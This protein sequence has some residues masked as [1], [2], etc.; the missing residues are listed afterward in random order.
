MPEPNRRSD[1]AS[2]YHIVIPTLHLRIAVVRFA[3]RI[4][5]SFFLFSQNSGIS[6]VRFLVKTVRTCMG[7]G[8]AR[9]RCSFPANPFSVFETLL[10]SPKFGGFLDT[11]L[12]RY[13]LELIF[14]DLA[15]PQG[16]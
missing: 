6:I 10:D 4:L 16:S 2:S 15:V 12:Y 1:S 3:F 8:P 5:L 7:G 9:I 14:D 13:M 11:S